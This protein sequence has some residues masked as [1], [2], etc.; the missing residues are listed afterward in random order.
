MSV[1]NRQVIMHAFG[2]LLINVKYVPGVGAVGP[3]L[4]SLMSVMRTLLH[5][6][7]PSWSKRAIRSLP[8]S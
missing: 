2:P 6:D 1:V 3:N 5:L 7:T 4:R 8:V